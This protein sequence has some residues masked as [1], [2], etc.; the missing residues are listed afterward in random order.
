MTP[1][2]RLLRRLSTFANHGRLWL[3]LGVLL[4]VRKGPL[5]RG[6]VRG[7]GSMAFSSALVNLLLKRFFGRVRP[8]LENLQSHRRLR[9]EPGS[10]SFPSGHSSSAAAFVTGLAMESPLAG[11]ALAP[12]A[13]S[14]GYS[15]VHVGVHYPGD[16]VAGLAVG[17]AVAAATQHWWRVRPKQPA[18][19][20]DS[21][22]APALPDGE[23]LV[24]AVNPRSGPDDYDPAA[25]IRRLLPRAEVLEMTGDAGVTELLG[26]AADSGR[27]K[28]LGVAGGDGSVAAAAAVA[29]ER[30]L[31]LAVIAAGTLNHFARDVGLETPQDTADA[32]VSGEAVKVDVA[33]VNGTPFLNT[34]SIGAYPEMVRRRDEL[35]GRMGKW[36]A[37]TVAAAQ[38]LRHQ[39]P[40]SLVVN[41]QPL[42][43]WILFIGN[44]LY[45]PRGLS[46]AWRPR[47]EDG[48]LD[49]QYLRAD[50][51]FGRTRTVL[52]TLLGV[53]EHTRS[54][55][56]FAAEEVRVVSR[57][58]PKQVAYDGEMGEKAT[59]F[60]FRKRA[61][62]TVY[63]CR[64]D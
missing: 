49:V 10:L 44:C 8:D 61:P 38:V 3:V 26:E 64:T 13:L 33:D 23:G 30:G 7:L 56:H 36:L 37:L 11:A 47:L 63:C 27:P 19:V 58:G 21:S 42:S 25:V 22:E 28:A 46:P 1:A 29:I 55:G 6:A 57:S 41:G 59:E 32:V 53:S 43:V 2:D 51:R 24:V 15:R 12:V 16:V 20:R 62:L 60:H 48:L 39:A 18:R 5:R 54:Y 35:S 45:T 4:G 31:P 14:V 9:R 34:S 52:A 50:L 17:G 40:V